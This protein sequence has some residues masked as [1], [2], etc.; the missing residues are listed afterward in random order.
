MLTS[1]TRLSRLNNTSSGTGNSTDAHKSI[2]SESCGFAQWRMSAR[3]SWKCLVDRSR[4]ASKCK[5]GDREAKTVKEIMCMCIYN[6]AQTIY[7]Q[8]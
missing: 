5:E 6:M 3:W 4:V 2:K 1:K 8:L 7:Y